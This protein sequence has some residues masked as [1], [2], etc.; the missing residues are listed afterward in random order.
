MREYIKLCDV[1]DFQGGSQ[2]PKDEWSSDFKAGYIRM[3][4]IRDFTQSERVAPEYIKITK[5]TKTCEVDDILI[6]RYGASLGKILTGL[7]GA[8]NVAIMRTI[9]DT[10][11]LEKKY[12]YY[13]LKS[14]VFQG[15]LLNVGSRAAQA[16]FNKNDLQDLFIPNITRNEQVK[17]VGILE[18]V[19]TVIEARQKEL[20]KLDD[21]IKARFIEMFGSIYDGEYE[22]KTLPEMVNEDKNAIKRGPFGG[23]LKKDDFVE[24]GYLVYEQRHAIHNDFDYAKYYIT[25]K[26]YDEM[27]GFKVVPGD[28]I[29]S[30]SGVTLGRIAEVPKG[31]KEGIINQALLKLS[32][33]QQIMLNTFFIHQFRGEEIQEILFGFS[34]GSGIPNMPSMSEV[35]SVKFICPPLELQKEYCDFVQQVDKSR[36]EVKKSLEKTQQ[37][38]DSLMQEYFG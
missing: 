17:I 24:N 33:N 26:K 29:I 27:I 32:L 10:N 15:F 2:P 21:L 12:L 38:Y 11:V 3:L 25:Q 22:L 34:R 9:P 5:T 31:A 28:L 18:R 20:Q 4:Q 7:A 35:K 23:A 6:A 13:Y 8:Y 16:G 19:E 14:P 1:C 36:E 37:L 30:C